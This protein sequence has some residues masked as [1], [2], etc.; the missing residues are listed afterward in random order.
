MKKDKG[1]VVKM[2]REEEF[3]ESEPPIEVDVI[4]GDGT[5]NG[6]IVQVREAGD[7][8]VTALIESALFDQIQQREQKTRGKGTKKDGAKKNEKNNKKKD[9]AKKNEKEDS[10][11]GLLDR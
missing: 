8:N 4:E 11:Y 7:E 2:G 9:G 1:F 5:Q 6:D 3:I 10:K